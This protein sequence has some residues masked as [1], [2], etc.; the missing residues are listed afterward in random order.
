MERKD[1]TYGFWFSALMLP[2]PELQE[3]MGFLMSQLKAAFPQGP[4][5]LLAPIGTPTPVLSS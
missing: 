2:C 4:E 1:E 5:Q 3:C